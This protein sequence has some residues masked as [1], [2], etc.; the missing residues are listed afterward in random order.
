VST[1]PLAWEASEPYAMR[2]PPRRLEIDI[3]VP[4]LMWI[5]R[6]VP[7]LLCFPMCVLG[8]LMLGMWLNTGVVRSALLAGTSMPGAMDREGFLCEYAG[9]LSSSAEY[10]QDERPFHCR[11]LVK[12]HG[13][14]WES[15]V[16][17]DQWASPTGDM[18]VYETLLKSTEDLEVDRPATLSVSM[19]VCKD[20][21]SE[22]HWCWRSTQ[23]RNRHTIFLHNRDCATDGWRVGQTMAWLTL[24]VGE[25]LTILSGR[26]DTFCL[27]DFCG[28]PRFVVCFFL[29][30]T[31]IFLQMH[32][33][34]VAK[35]LDLEPLPFKH[36]WQPL[37][38]AVAVCA[39]NEIFKVLY[40]FVLNK[41]NVE[42]EK[43]ALHQ[44]RRRPRYEG[45]DCSSVEQADSVSMV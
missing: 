30:L 10:L 41:Q 42:Q 24:T 18:L 25:T 21:A 32:L 15:F 14:P 13:L 11:C 9:V 36:L 8:S 22:K 28:N 19:E 4:K 44:T 29:N 5:F 12:P 7:F 2:V 34:S 38:F 1:L 6:W 39:L 37:V 17:I 33:P 16:E 3:V 45:S 20:S 27:N 31:L 23:G 40:V 26:R 43:Q 35:N